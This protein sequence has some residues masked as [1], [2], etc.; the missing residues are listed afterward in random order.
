LFG[1]NKLPNEGLRPPV[2]ANMVSAMSG[3]GFRS[4]A[5][6]DLL[7]N[8]NIEGWSWILGSFE[9]WKSEL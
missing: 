7:G 6:V 5:L 9:F 1:Q 4:D 3:L 2:S 8:A